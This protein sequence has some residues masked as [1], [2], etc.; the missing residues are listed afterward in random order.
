M[1]F[2]LN[3]KNEISNI[4]PNKHCAMA[5]FFSILN[6]AV[7]IKY[8]P[9]ALSLS[10]ENRLLA[11][12]FENLLKYLFNCE[13]FIFYKN[14]KLYIY[15][16]N[17]LKTIFDTINKYFYKHNSNTYYINKICCKRAYIRGAFL[18]TGYICSPEKNYHVEFLSNN[19]EKAKFLKDLINYF[20]IEAKILEK[21]DYFIVYIKEADQI[22]ELL[23]V[24]EAHKALMEFENIR[25]LKEVRN[26]VNRIVNCETANLNKIVCAGME[27]KE[28][29]EYIK[30]TI[31][32]DSLPKPLKE[33]A[34][35]RLENPD[36]SLQELSE[37]TNPRISK[38]GVNHRL[39][40]INN[41]SKK[42]R[43]L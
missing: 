1:S 25:I 27:Q 24:I 26:N 41:I 4:L 40:K 22:I 43:G 13:E 8:S 21:K 42:L 18:S 7:N 11:D 2:S 6:F 16:S 12:K 29:I 10:T 39:K 3:V 33:I 19:L 20:E 36:I 28:N 14:S 32:L 23:N 30:N 37:M 34:L 9:L 17:F 5:E 31:G 15:D 35:L 38:S